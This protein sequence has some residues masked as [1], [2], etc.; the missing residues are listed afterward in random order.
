MNAMKIMLGAAAG[1]G[2]AGCVSVLPEPAAPDAVYSF[3][4]MGAVK[5]APLYGTVVVREPDG[6]RLMSGRNVIVDAGGGS[7]GV[8]AKSQWADNTTVMMQ[9]A[10]VDALNAFGGSGVALDDSS[11]A[12]GDVEVFW[13][14]RDFSAGSDSAT[15]TLTV[16]IL[17]GRSRAPLAREDFEAVVPIRG[18]RVNAMRDA[19]REAISE[20]AEFIRSYTADNLAE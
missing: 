7:L 16:T 6:P 10:L 8:D 11:G 1:L 19:S 5:S 18:N 2:L 4:D 15:M 9:Y 20:A 13:R 17:E 14:I 3:Y 12:R